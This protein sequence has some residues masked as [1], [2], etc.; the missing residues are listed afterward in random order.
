MTDHKTPDGMP[1]PGTPFSAPPL[2]DNGDIDAD[3]LAAM[4]AEAE[5]QAAQAAAT[6]GQPRAAAPPAPE[7]N[8]TGGPEL[9]A[10]GAGR[11]L[12]LALRG[13][14]EIDTRMKIMQLQLFLGVGLISLALLSVAI[15]YRAKLKVKGS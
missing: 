12:T 14:E 11:D 10:R 15:A 3:A 7:P 8:W 13:L 5:A 4:Y 2:P 6:N 9:D 1:P